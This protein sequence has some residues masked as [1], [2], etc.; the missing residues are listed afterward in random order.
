MSE[1]KDTEEDLLHAALCRA[2]VY[3]NNGEN[4]KAHIE[5]RMALN[6]YADR[7]DAKAKK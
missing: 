1:I 7:A 6:E 3:M 4:L 2:C 5:I